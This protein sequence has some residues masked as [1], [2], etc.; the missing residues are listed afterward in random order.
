M[1]HVPIGTTFDTDYEKG[2]VS[3]TEPDSHGN[4]L[5][6]DSDGVICSYHVLMIAGELGD[7]IRSELS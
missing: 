1:L 7:E 5:A 2:C 4:F 6:Q 3:M